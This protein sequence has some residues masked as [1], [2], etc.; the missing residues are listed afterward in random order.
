MDT[1]AGNWLV[2]GESIVSFIVVSSI[3]FGA[4]LILS[5]CALW[6]GAKEVDDDL[7]FR[8]SMFCVIESSRSFA[9]DQMCAF[10]TG[11]W[12]GLSNSL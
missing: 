10:A 4:T 9:T 3:I 5:F 7:K 2:F 6:E 1:V 8:V 12:G 11:A